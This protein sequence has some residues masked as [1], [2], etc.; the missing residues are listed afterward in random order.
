MAPR[1]L[2]CPTPLI[3]DFGTTGLSL[4]RG[5][6]LPWRV[7]CAEGPQVWSWGQTHSEHCRPLIRMLGATRDAVAGVFTRRPP[8]STVSRKSRFAGWKEVGRV[9]EGWRQSTRKGNRMNSEVGKRA[10][11]RLA[12]GV[13]A[14]GRG[15]TRPLGS[16]LKAS[17]RLDSPPSSRGQHRTALTPRSHPGGQPQPRGSPGRVPSRGP[18]RLYPNS[19]AAATWDRTILRRRRGEEKSCPRTPSPGSQLEPPLHSS[20]SSEF[21]ALLLRPRA[22]RARPPGPGPTGGSRP[23]TPA[24]GT[25]RRAPTRGAGYKG[26]AAAA[27]C[28]LERDAS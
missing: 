13:G 20:P 2:C 8:L 18:R 3:P 5:Y 10:V 27:D 14:R 7:P 4:S 11:G 22:A 12:R 1:L 24:R 6:R 23:P 17:W 9:D 15:V 26:L 19:R 25:A 28:G 21:C 16:A